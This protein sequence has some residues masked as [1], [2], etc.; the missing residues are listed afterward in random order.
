MLSRRYSADQ[1]AQYVADLRIVDHRHSPWRMDAMEWA[2]GPALRPNPYIDE[3]VR[4][5]VVIP[6][7]CQ[8]V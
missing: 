7:G 3:L 2:Y 1:V 4:L 6:T 8:Y 5:Q